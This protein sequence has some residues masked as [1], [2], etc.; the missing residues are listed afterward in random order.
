VKRTGFL[1]GIAR[2]TGAARSRA[3]D[4]HRWNRFR[5]HNTHTSAVTKRRAANKRARIARR[6]AR[7]Q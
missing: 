4:A 6:I 2:L 5:G 3:M 7:S 1:A